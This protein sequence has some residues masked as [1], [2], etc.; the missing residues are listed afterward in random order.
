MFFPEHRIQFAG[1]V[2][3][4][5]FNALSLIGAIAALTAGQKVQQKCAERGDD[6]S[7]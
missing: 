6:C 5:I 4:A 2:I 7:S 3:T 1:A